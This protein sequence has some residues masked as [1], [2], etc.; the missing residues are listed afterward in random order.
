MAGNAMRV[1]EPEF[2]FRMARDLAPRATPYSVDDVLN[3]V[4]TLHPAIELPDSRFADFVSA[5]KRN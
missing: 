2:A 3:A 4:A 1:G 5:A